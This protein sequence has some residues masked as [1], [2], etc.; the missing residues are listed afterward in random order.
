MTVGRAQTLVEG[1]YALE[2]WFC[3]KRGGHEEERALTHAVEG[4]DSGRLP[5]RL[6]PL[7]VYGGADGGRF[8]RRGRQ[9]RDGALESAELGDVQLE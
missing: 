8:Q 3:D 5:R 6:E 9:S 7:S 1:K 2:G 4:M